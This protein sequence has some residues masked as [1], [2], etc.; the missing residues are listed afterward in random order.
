MSLETLAYLGEFIGGVV[1]FV[2]LIYL[3]RQVHQNTSSLRTE[4]YA[5]ALERVAAIQAR[6]S[7]D[8]S[9][10]NVFGRGV[11]HA[12]VLTPQ[13]RIQFAWAFYEMFGA[14]EFMFH[15][16]QD[17]ALAQ[18]VWGRWSATLA[19]WIS[20]PGVHAWWQA[21][22][23]PFTPAFSALVESY[24]RDGPSDPEAARR[25]TLF[26]RGENPS[27]AGGDGTQAR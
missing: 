17:G 23:T 8:P 4:N 13:E 18:E 10:A 21:K 5:R 1:V 2:S 25:W 9:L 26:L 12:D 16:A 15:Q 20:L 14:F 19:W 6:L 22:P 3:A 24:V 7:T 11:L 27:R